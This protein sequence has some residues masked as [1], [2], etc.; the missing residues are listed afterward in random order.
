MADSD[1]WPETDSPRLT[2]STGY[3]VTLPVYGS[4]SAPSRP[5]SRTSAQPSASASPSTPSTPRLSFPQRLGQQAR[6]AGSLLRLVN[7]VTSSAAVAEVADRATAPAV[8]R[9]APSVREAANQFSH[10][11]AGNQNP[12]APLPP[13]AP[14]GAGAR[15]QLTPGEESYAGIGPIPESYQA[16]TPRLPET[17]VSAPA[18]GSLNTF[19]AHGD[20]PRRVNPA[21]PEEI[22]AQARRP[23]TVSAPDSTAPQVQDTTARAL[24]GQ[25][26]ATLT[27]RADAADILNPMSADAEIMR[28]LQNSQRSYFNRG[29]P[30]ARAAQAAAYA[31]QLEAR[32]RASSM[33]QDA[34]NAMLQLGAVGEGAAAESAADRRQRADE[35]NVDRQQAAVDRDDFARS[36]ARQELIRGQDGRVTYIRQDGT[37]A[38]LRDEEGQPVLTPGPQP[39]ALSLRDLLESYNAQA[40][41]VAGGLGS[42]DEKRQQLEALRADGLYAPLFSRDTPAAPSVGE[43]RNGY[44]FRGG[45]PSNRENWERES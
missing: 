44:R 21:T 31:G 32:N 25:R 26:R 36:P 16:R 23:A 18:P 34:A 17:V 43:V 3:G 2:M 8:Q 45:D 33:G 15:P 9:L 28:R 13:P 37:A 19:G 10:G 39:D 30:S 6:T 29:S 1:R 24:D 14:E 38:T 12:A 5:R 42:P 41:A 22:A 35:F 27:A 7:P 4:Q 20:V 11:L 40:E